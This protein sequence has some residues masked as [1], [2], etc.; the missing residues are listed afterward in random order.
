MRFEDRSVELADR[1][2][3]I[4]DN[5]D[6]TWVVTGLDPTDAVKHAAELSIFYTESGP[7]PAA[8]VRRLDP[9]RRVEIR[10]IARRTEEGLLY[11]V[12]ARTQRLVWTGIPD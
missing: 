4:W 7:R 11:A 10:I 12:G 3:G 1:D 5:L 2:R 8:H 9:P 6:G